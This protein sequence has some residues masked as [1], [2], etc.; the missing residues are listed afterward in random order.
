MNDELKTA[1]TEFWDGKETAK[2]KGKETT[3]E[4]YFTE[5]NTLSKNG[6]LKCIERATVDITARTLSPKKT[7]TNGW[8]KNS[9]APELAD[10]GKLCE[11]IMQWL[12]NTNAQKSYDDWHKE[13]CCAVLKIIQAHYTNQDKERTAVCYGKAQKL[14]NMAMK[15]VYCLLCKEQP[16]ILRK[17]C[18]RFDECHIPLDS[19]TLKWYREHYTE[20]KTCWSKLEAEEYYGIS[21]NIKAMF[22]QKKLEDKYKDLTPLQAEF[23]IW[24][25]EQMKELAVNLGKNCKKYIKNIAVI[26]KLG[27]QNEFKSAIDLYKDIAGN[28]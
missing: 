16:D 13:A 12:E 27:L 25:E 1:I 23:F 5:S 28:Q 8:I 24:E 4:Y 2:I 3:S 17:Y 15:T 22:D 21:K 7:H 20:Q 10:A 14:V 19:Y 26:E 6:I 9:F 18:S 11:N